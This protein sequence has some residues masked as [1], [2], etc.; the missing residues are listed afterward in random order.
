MATNHAHKPTSICKFAASSTDKAGK[1]EYFQIPKN[2]Y[3]WGTSEFITG[4]GVAFEE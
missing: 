1:I 3:N 4:D 2:A